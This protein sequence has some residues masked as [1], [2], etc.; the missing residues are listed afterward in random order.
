[1][2]AT[3]GSLASVAATLR[4]VGLAGERGTEL[5]VVHVTTP[6]SD[7][8]VEFGEASLDAMHVHPVDG[9]E[10]A[11]YLSTQAGVRVRSHELRGSVVDSILEAAERLGA[12]TLVLGETGSQGLDPAGAGG[13][14][15]AVQDRCPGRQVIVVPGR[16]EDVVP[17]LREMFTTSSGTLPA[18]AS[19]D[20]DVNW[21]AVVREPS[22]QELVSMKAR[23]LVPVTVVALTCYLGVNVLAGFARGIMSESVVGALNVG[24]VLIIALYVMTWVVALVYVRVANRTFDAKAVEAAAAFEK[25]RRSR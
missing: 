2:L 24:Y 21:A 25:W 11:R 1:M 13:V 4:A 22:F 7:L 19:I 15:R 3:D 5:H 9:L 23:F 14:A 16:A 6:E 17:V 8:Q 10:A 12:E 20:P 18:S